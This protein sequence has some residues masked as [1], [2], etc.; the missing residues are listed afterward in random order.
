MKQKMKNEKTNKEKASADSV[1]D[2]LCW[3]TRKNIAAIL[4]LHIK[5]PPNMSR[6]IYTLICGVEAEGL[7]PKIGKE[8]LDKLSMG[9]NSI[10]IYGVWAKG[11]G[12]FKNVVHRV[13]EHHKF[14]EYHGERAK[15]AICILYCAL[16]ELKYGDLLSLLLLPEHFHHLEDFRWQVV[17]DPT[18]RNRA[19]LVVGFGPFGKLKGNDKR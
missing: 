4:A 7:C 11:E 2:E 16:S 6:S 14:Q 1:Q 10:L 19:Y 8:C 15:R 12:R 5:L 13:L 17:N 3:R 9:E 18:L